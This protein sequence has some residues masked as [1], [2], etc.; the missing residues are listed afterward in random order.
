MKN[1]TWQCL[2]LAKSISIKIFREKIVILIRYSGLLVIPPKSP[3]ISMKKMI[4]AEGT[5]LGWNRKRKQKDNK[6]I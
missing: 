3:N 5:Q 2:L 4:L 6:H 1:S